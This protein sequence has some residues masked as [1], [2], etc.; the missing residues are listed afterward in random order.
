[1]NDKQLF[2]SLLMRYRTNQ[3]YIDH[4]PLDYQ[5]MHDNQYLYIAMEKLIPQSHY[6]EINEVVYG[7][8]RKL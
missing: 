7:I 6:D 2:E 1:M 8:R 3:W 4:N 5:S